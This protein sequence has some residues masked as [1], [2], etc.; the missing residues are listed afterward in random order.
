MPIEIVQVGDPVLRNGTRALSPAEVR[1]PEIRQLI[2][3]M[4]ETMR[5]APGVGLAAPQVGLPLRLAVI[6]DVVEDLE[7]DRRPGRLSRDCQPEC[8]DLRL[9]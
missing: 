8:R 3:Q 6:E 7:L 9:C 4:R 2:E 5:Q 1:S